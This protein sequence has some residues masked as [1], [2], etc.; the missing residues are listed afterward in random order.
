MARV[1]VGRG[2]DQRDVVPRGLGRR[3]RDR[4]AELELEAGERERAV[5]VAA[6]ALVLLARGGRVGVRL[7]GARVLQS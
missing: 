7:V 2:A 6:A 4:A 3:G 1:R 5:V